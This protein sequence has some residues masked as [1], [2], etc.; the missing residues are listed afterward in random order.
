VNHTI[1]NGFLRHG[2]IVY[3]QFR[4]LIHRAVLKVK[5]W[6]AALS[7]FSFQEGQPRVG[8]LPVPGSKSADNSLPISLDKLDLPW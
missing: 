7:A 2:V 4:P 6:E 3:L 1:R 5:I 8:V